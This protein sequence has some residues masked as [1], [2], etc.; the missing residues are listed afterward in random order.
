[1]R[2]TN[3]SNSDANNN[4]NSN[5]NDNS[6][7]NNNNNNRDSNINRHDIQTRVGIWS[8]CPRVQGLGFG[9]RGSQHCLGVI[10]AGE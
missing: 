4:N 9:R 2:D 10:G 6:S 3:S 8:G 7:S 5:S 1:M